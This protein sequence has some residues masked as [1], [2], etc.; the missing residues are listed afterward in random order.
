MKEKSTMSQNFKKIGETVDKFGVPLILMRS[1]AIDFTPAFLPLWKGWVEI[2]EK[3]WAM[4]RIHFGNSTPVVWAERINGKFVGAVNYR[5]IPEDKSVWILM[6]VT[7]EDERQKGINN[8]LL[9]EVERLSKQMGATTIGSTIHID[10]VGALK[11]AEKT[12]RKILFYRT[13]KEI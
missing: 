12:G 11:S 7:E 10:N 3:G 5:W 1:D 4:H 9:A 13:H 6:T 8:I 2:Y